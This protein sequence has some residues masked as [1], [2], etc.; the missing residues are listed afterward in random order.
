MGKSFNEN[1]RVKIPAIVH[2]TRL[3]YKYVSLKAAEQKID[4]ETNIYK[5]SFRIA[6]NRINGINLTDKDA[7]S[8][9][10]DLKNLLDAADLGRNFHVKFFTGVSFADKTIRMIDFDD[11]NNN[12]FEVMTEVPYRSGSDSF[13]PDITIFV[14]GL[15]LAFVEVKIPDNKQ[16]IQAEHKRMSE[17]FLQEKYKRF[18][19]ITQLMI[20][21]NNS[22]YDDNEIV[23]LEGA[24]YAASDYR[25]LF[26]NRFREEDSDIYNQIAPLDEVVEKAILKDTNYL[27]IRATNEY[28]TNKSPLT[29]TNKI[30]TSLFSRK[31]FYLFC[32]TALLMSKIRMKA[33]SRR[34]KST[35]C[36]ISKCSPSSG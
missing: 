10:S 23:L 35:S 34:L 15:P 27:S 36:V 25:K 11:P 30:L 19:N 8:I 2:L 21:S 6:L 22:E 18:A 24:F 14:N 9:I 26:F 31:D 17:R 1:S 4:E 3:N 32:V 33:E 20:F 13:R 12:T 5:E 7:D 28:E 29:P 16:G